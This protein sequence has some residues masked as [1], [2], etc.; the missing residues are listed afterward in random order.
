MKKKVIL[1][2]RPALESRAISSETCSNILVEDNMNWLKAAERLLVLL[3]IIL[4]IDDSEN[5][6]AC[7][8][9]HQRCGN[10]F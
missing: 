3:E 10:F 1:P 4:Q 6:C 9:N 8:F 7:E 5:V 2:R